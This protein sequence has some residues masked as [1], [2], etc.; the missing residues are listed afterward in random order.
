MDI[1]VG[2]CYHFQGHLNYKRGILGYFI[3]SHFRI[4]Q[5]LPSGE[6]SLVQ[7]YSLRKHAHMRDMCSDTELSNIEIPLT[8]VSLIDE[9]DH[10][11]SN[12]A[13]IN[14]T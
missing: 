1:V 3:V 6:Y 8:G 9:R 10:E 4:R 12:V 14:L 2:D 7:Y 5:R 11:G 13:S